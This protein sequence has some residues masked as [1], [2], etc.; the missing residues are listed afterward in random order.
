MVLCVL[1]QRLQL[2]VKAT[3]MC[4]S[5]VYICVKDVLGP[6]CV[7]ISVDVQGQ[8]FPTMCLEYQVFGHIH[9]HGPVD[10]FFFKSAG[11]NI[12]SNIVQSC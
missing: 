4:S 5:T 12:L 7:Y 11:Q 9:A 6:S 8:I 2:E 10:T 1:E 3:A